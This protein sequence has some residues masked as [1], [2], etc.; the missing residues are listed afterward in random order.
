MS[1]QQIAEDG[2]LIDARPAGSAHFKFLERYPQPFAGILYQLVW[3]VFSNAMEMEFSAMPKALALHYSTYGHIEALAQAIAEGVR[4][5]GAAADIKRVPETAPEEVAKACHFKLDQAAPVA[6]IG[7]LIEYDAIIVGTGTSYAWGKGCRGLHF[8]GEPAWRAGNH[9]MVPVRRVR[10]NWRQ[11]AIRE[12]LSRKRQGSCLADMF[13][14][15]D[16]H[17]GTAIDPVPRRSLLAEESSMCSMRCRR[18]ITNHHV[19][20]ISPLR[21]A[22]KRS[23]KLYIA[24]SDRSAPRQR[25]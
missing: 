15:F 2:E 11:P 1:G 3:L 12:G 23:R 24:P 18:V 21:T 10:T 17:I 14:F 9:A 16:L 19:P 20:E 7:D 25:Q 13:Q 5:A 22:E 4:S 8:V 6:R